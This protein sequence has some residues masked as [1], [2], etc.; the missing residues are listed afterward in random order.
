MEMNCFSL[1]HKLIDALHVMMH[2]QC[3]EIRG[4]YIL[5]PRGWQDNCVFA[6]NL[7]KMS[8]YF[9]RI[10]FSIGH[11]ILGISRCPFH[12]LLSTERF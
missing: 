8:G 1:G 4:R 2:I 6:I 10:F 11:V 3:S 5:L 7:F 9:T 12:C